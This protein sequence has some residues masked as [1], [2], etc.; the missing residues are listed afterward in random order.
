MSLPQQKLLNKSLFRIVSTS[1]NRFSRANVSGRKKSVPP[2]HVDLLLED[3]QFKIMIDPAS[4]LNY[5]NSPK[6]GKVFFYKITD[7]RLF[8]LL[9]L[10]A[11]MF[12]T[13][14]SMSFTGETIN[15]LETGS[16]KEV[17][18]ARL[19]SNIGKYDDDDLDLAMDVRAVHHMP[20]P[21]Q[22]FHM[23][24]NYFTLDHTNDKHIPEIE[25]IAYTYLT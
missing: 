3:N 12:K 13:Q 1:P 17:F 7:Y 25:F 22:E 9:N 20:E 8:D 6:Y 11:L 23:I 21:D 16:G 15:R 19:Y 5:T 24:T 2:A 4:P 14:R 10:P 18:H